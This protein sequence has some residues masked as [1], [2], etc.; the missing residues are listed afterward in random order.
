MEYKKKGNSDVDIYTIGE[1]GI[2]GYKEVTVNKGGGL[3]TGGKA[4]DNPVYVKVKMTN[5]PNTK[6]ILD[7][8]KYEIPKKK[9][10]TEDSS[11]DVYDGETG[12]LIAPK[13]SSYQDMHDNPDIPFELKDST[14]NTKI[15]TP[16]EK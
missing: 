16:T 14:D 2:A 11:V 12:T 9:I 7:R 5:K 15:I 3:H 4:S 13:K 1:K 10:K 8:E 6:V